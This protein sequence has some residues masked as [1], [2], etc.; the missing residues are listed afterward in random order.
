MT[1]RL[2][3]QVPNKLA[4]QHQPSEENGWRIVVSHSGS[5]TV[6]PSLSQITSISNQE[7]PLSLQAQAQ[8]EFT[9]NRV[10][11]PLSRMTALSLGFVTSKPT[12]FEQTARLLPSYNSG[13][14]GDPA[15]R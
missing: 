8:V 1:A 4:D 5:Q 10:T 2:Q 15:E 11:I 9:L 3:M 13:A 6:R 7:P 14:T 12:N